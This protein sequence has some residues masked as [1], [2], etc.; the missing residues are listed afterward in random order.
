M[1]FLFVFYCFLGGTD[2]SLSHNLI[3]LCSFRQRSVA[4]MLF[5]MVWL[6]CIR[7]YSCVAKMRMAK[8]RK[9]YWMLVCKCLSALFAAAHHDRGRACTASQPPVFLRDTGP[10]CGTWPASSPSPLR[11]SRSTEEERKQHILFFTVSGQTRG[12][13]LRN[14]RCS[15]TLR[16]WG[17]RSLTWIRLCF[18]LVFLW[19]RDALWNGFRLSRCLTEYYYN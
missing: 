4:V 13:K 11:R 5:L 10:R 17:S 15:D 9:R 8:I 6:F 3:S 1:C 12:S 14:G 2:V 7:I 16:R 18:W 19:I